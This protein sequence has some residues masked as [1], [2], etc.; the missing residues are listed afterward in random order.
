[1]KMFLFLSFF[2]FNACALEKGLIFDWQRPALEPNET[3]QFASAQETE[4]PESTVFNGERS[5]AGQK[6]VIV[7][8]KVMDENSQIKNFEMLLKEGEIK[9]LTTGLERSECYIRYGDLAVAIMCDSRTKAGGGVE[10]TT[11]GECARDGATSIVKEFLKNGKIIKVRS[12]S[13]KCGQGYK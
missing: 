13:A 6:S 10:V 5:S 7:E 2:S 9:A 4:K 8:V 11:F 3:I 1:M 12:I